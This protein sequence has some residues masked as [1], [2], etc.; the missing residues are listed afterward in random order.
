MVDV[1]D[2]SHGWNGLPPTDGVT[3]SL[4]GD[5]RVIVRPSGTEPKLKCYLQ[6]V[7]PV[8]VGQLAAAKSAS[9]AALT[10]VAA[11]LGPALGLG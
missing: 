3:L 11:D 2:L 4:G 7:I 10:A 1:I 6:I 8:L 5:D 9:A